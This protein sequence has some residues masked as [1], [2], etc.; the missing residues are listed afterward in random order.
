MKGFF[1]APWRFAACYAA[2]LIAA[3]TWALLDTLN[4][5][6]C[7]GE[8]NEAMLRLQRE[9]L[10]KPVAEILFGQDKA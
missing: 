5:T 8:V 9:A 1:Q 4:G 3:F 2:F 6:S 10:E 7:L